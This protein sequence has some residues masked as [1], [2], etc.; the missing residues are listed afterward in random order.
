ML[1]LANYNFSNFADVYYSK[2]LY[3][4]NNTTSKKKEEK[5]TLIKVSKIQILD[6]KKRITP[7]HCGQESIC[8]V[9]KR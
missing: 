7:L 2:H 3:I 9:K 1:I 8:K 4:N 5:K 6:L